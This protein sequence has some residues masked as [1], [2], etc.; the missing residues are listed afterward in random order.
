V[1]IVIPPKISIDHRYRNKE[2]SRALT[3]ARVH[4]SRP[5]YSQGTTYDDPLY[6]KRNGALLIIL[7]AQKK[8]K[9]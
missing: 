6:D 8:V 9:K 3:Q 5:P 7:D 1:F 2:K 4:I